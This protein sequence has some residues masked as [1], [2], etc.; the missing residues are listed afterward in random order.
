MLCSSAASKRLVVDYETPE[1]ATVQGSCL[2]Q[3]VAYKQTGISPEE[4]EGKGRKTT[5]IASCHSYLGQD[6]EV[7]SFCLLRVDSQDLVWNPWGLRPG[8]RRWI[9]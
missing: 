5:A 3:K 2:N 4:S 7:R 1:Y 8:I 6:G 9:L